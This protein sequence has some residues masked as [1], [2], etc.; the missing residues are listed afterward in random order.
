MSAA[1]VLLGFRGCLS[2][3]VMT[4]RYDES[5]QVGELGGGSVV[6]HDQR[7]VAP[8]VALELCGF[9]G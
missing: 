5:V 2:G 6:L 9:G 8:R 7:S 4:S 1:A 3:V